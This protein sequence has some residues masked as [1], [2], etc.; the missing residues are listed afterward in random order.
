MENQF[1]L[2]AV[3]LLGG[4]ILSTVAFALNCF[5]I[6]YLL[7]RYQLGWE[8]YRS[9]ALTSIAFLFVTW[10]TLLIGSGIVLSKERK[11]SVSGQFA[12]LLS[13]YVIIYI[14]FLISAIISSF[15]LAQ[16]QLT[17]TTDLQIVR[18]YFA[19]ILALTG[20]ALFWVL[21]SGG[22]ALKRSTK[23]FQQAI[24]VQEDLIPTF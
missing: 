11:A 13:I 12:A 23:T 22:I 16:T 10:V 2:L 18:T 3:S 21:I 14:G 17:L 5:L 1:T 9:Y 20:V 7:I 24:E 15:G 19:T 4:L 6:G 8:V